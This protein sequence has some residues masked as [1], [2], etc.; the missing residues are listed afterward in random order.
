MKSTGI[1]EWTDKENE[2]KEDIS[3]SYE[4]YY[5]RFRIIGLFRISGFFNIVTILNQNENSEG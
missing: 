5:T 3:L 2:R 4:K 1:G